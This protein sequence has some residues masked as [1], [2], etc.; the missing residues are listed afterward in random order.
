MLHD[1]ASLLSDLQTIF[2]VVDLLQASER[3]G[4]HLLPTPQDD[5]TPRREPTAL[6][7]VPYRGPIDETIR[8]LQGGVRSACTCAIGLCTT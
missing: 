2:V 3:F 1:V 4:S 7:K 8:D 6:G 5:L